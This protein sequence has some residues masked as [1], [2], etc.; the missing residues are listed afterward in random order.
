MS[1]W[2]AQ[3]DYLHA[4]VEDLDTPRSLRRFSGRKPSPGRRVEVMG[5]SIDNI[6]AAA[7]VERMVQS[8]TSGGRSLVL[9]V[10]AHFLNLM[11]DH[12]LLR[13]INRYADVTLCDSVGAQLAALA[14][15]GDVLPRNTPPDWIY[16]LGERLGRSGRSVFWFGGRPETV[17]LAAKN[18]ES[19]TGARSVGWHHGYV[20]LS[21]DSPDGKLLVDRIN[22]LEP[23]VLIVCLGMPLQEEWL[24]RH[25]TALNVRVAITGGA[26]IDHVAGRVTRPPSWITRCGLEWAARLVHEPRRLWRRYLVGLPMLGGRLIKEIVHL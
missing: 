1:V 17:E 16:M 18:F 8:V 9:H 12:P 26:L 21:P 25:W 6:T 7:A 2:V 11:F 3:Q 10:N 20:D 4:L 19:K 14:V 24:H 15:S 13:A 5:V 23:D 22:S